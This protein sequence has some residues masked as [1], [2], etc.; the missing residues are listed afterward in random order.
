MSLFYNH[1]L[2]ALA[3]ASLAALAFATAAVFWS[4]P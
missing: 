4:N 2:G 1:P 3:V